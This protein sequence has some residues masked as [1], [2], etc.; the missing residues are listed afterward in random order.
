MK[1][2]SVILSGYRRPHTLLEQYSSI[3]NQSLQVD[4]ILFWQNRHMGEIFDS[5]VLNQ[6][7]SV[8]SNHNF[9]VWSRF[10]FALNCKSDYIC[11]LDDDTIPG[12]RFLENCLTS[13][14]K[15]P[16]LYGTIGLIYPSSE[17]YHNAERV[18]W[19]GL[20]NEEI[21][22]VDI[23]GHAW[24]FSRE[25]LSIFWRELPDAECIY[26]GED[27]H[28]SFML[29]KYSNMKTYVPP[30]PTSNTSL[31]GSLKGSEYGGDINATGNF[32]VPM[33]DDY[34]RKIVGQG[35]KIL[36]ENTNEKF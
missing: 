16:G 29:Q 18:G 13:F 9:G 12:N 36:K 7:K 14:E 31:W 15:K 4:E 28:F 1:S 32:A 27:M 19:K 22:E 33:M 5:N 6:C 20:N 34:Y 21:E 26:V 35:F 17:T 10:A 24:F 23:V 25:M 30:H 11:I 3:I 2:I 8:I